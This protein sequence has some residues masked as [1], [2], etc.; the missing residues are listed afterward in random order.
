ML[1]WSARADAE[2]EAL[3]GAGEGTSKTVGLLSRR[4][5]VA[6]EFHYIGKEASTR[7]GGGLDLSMLAEAGAP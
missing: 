7:W 3:A 1:F 6:G 4:H 5:I 2:S